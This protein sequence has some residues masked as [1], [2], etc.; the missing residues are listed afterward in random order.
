MRSYRRSEDQMGE[1]LTRAENY[2]SL[3]GLVVLI[4][5][6]IGV[7]SVTRV[8]VQQ[9]L[10]SIAILKCVGAS[11]REIL[12]VY[13]TQVL[14][15]GIAGSLLGVG[16]AA[17]V[18]AAV[19]AFVGNVAAVLQV[20]YGLTAAAVAQGFAIGL[21]VSVLF[22]LV[23]LLDVRHVKPS[24][25]L[26]H[27]IPRLAAYRLGEVD[28]HGRRGRLPRGGRRL[29]GGLAASRPD[30]VG[31]VRGD[32]VRAEPGGPRARARG[33]AAAPFAI[34]RAAPGGSAR[35]ASRQPDARDPAG[36][37]PRH[38]LH[39]RRAH[40]AG[41]PAPGLRGAGRGGRA[42]H[43]PDRHPGGSEGQPR[44]V[45]R[46]GK[47]DGGAAERHSGP[48]GAGRRRPRARGEPRD[49]RAGARPRL[50]LA[51]VHDYLS[52]AA[53][54]QRGAAAGP[55]VGAHAVDGRS[56]SLDRGEPP[57]ALPHQH[58]RRDELRRARA[59]HSR[60]RHQ[61][62]Q[63]ELARLPIRRLH[64]RLPSRP[65]RQR[66]AFLHLVGERSARSGAR[67]AACRRRWSRATR[68]CR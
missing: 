2:L 53:Q 9:K 35:R 14:L 66:A 30:A 42:R 6:G 4:L 60:A 20:E 33:A 47:R 48:A 29:A 12:A 44:R 49:L 45:H 21:L 40:A 37:R 41:E 58:R 67:A 5:G 61:R 62:P 11:S 56:G 63:G 27:D 8:F 31:R 36:R 64:D 55:L 18:I 46:P 3:V 50:A 7:S 43:V 28:R 22:S 23:P 51:R 32:G 38:V 34:V 13:M 57:A 54:S 19:P 17:A 24:L 26:R 59:H 1:N 68:T 16:I 10:R 25:L 52:P 39:P 15:L 65:V